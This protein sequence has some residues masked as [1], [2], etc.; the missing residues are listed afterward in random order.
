MN[1]DV[2]GAF[3]RTAGHDVTMA[4][5]GQD[6]VTAA[7]GGDFDLILMDIRMPVMDGL[8]AAKCI[9]AL[10]GRRGRVPIIALTAHA[11][12][13]EIAQCEDAGMNGHVAKPV[14]YRTLVRAIDA[15]PLARYAA[16]SVSCP[17]EPGSKPRK[18]PALALDR[19]R[20]DETAGLLPRESVVDH[21]RSLRDRGEQM[22]S[23]LAGP[24][25]PGMTEAAHNAASTFGMF[26]FSAV[27]LITREFEYALMHDAPAAA[28]LVPQVR[29]G[30]EDAVAILTRLIL[31]RET[32]LALT[33]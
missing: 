26:G 19:T 16:G 21:L 13:T 11:F 4:E 7:R 31:E 12:P 1:R 6:A 33:H 28:L 18:E 9:R 29:A 23:M 8:E 3:L 14:D 30:T 27:S 24:G 32:R 25:R 17:N 10:P 15:Q 5:N 20:F 2:I 22:L